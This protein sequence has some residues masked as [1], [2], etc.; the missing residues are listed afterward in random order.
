MTSPEQYDSLLNA[1]I[2]LALQR[3]ERE[4]AALLLNCTIVGV[5]G[6]SWD[7]PTQTVFVNLGCPPE[8]L[9]LLRPYVAEPR[10]TDN[11][12]GPSRLAELFRD[13]WPIEE[14]VFIVTMEARLEPLEPGWRTQLA[15]AIESGPSNQGRPFG[16]SP[17]IVHS[18][19]NYRSKGEVAIAQTLELTEDILFLPNCTAVTGKVP[20]EPDFLIFYK[21]R[22]GVLE[23]DGP[24][25]AGRLADDTLKDSVY[26]RQSLFVKRYPYEH[27]IANPARVVRDFLG[28]LL[29]AR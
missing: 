1:G 16:T 28:L 6:Q 2:R 5:S 15:E 7:G 17:V 24:H 4:M 27:C 11:S 13:F 19:L 22:A 12:L 26:Q 8:L 20:S 23:V 10:L 3:G 18:G 21:G 29:K 14:W 25:H 9:D